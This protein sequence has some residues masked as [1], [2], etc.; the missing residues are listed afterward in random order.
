MESYRY[1]R[2]YFRI[3]TFR[4]LNFR[5]IYLVMTAFTRIFD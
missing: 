2:V 5:N 3:K 4:T 1:I